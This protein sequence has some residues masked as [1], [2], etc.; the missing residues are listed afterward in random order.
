M[1][2]KFEI[3]ALKNNSEKPDLFLKNGQKVQIVHNSKVTKKLTKKLILS[4]KY[5]QNFLP[6]VI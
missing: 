5:T 4:F 2:I 6:Q 3:I 1:D